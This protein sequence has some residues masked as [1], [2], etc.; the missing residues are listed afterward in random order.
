MELICE[1]LH[2]N[3]VGWGK[4]PR[5]SK[6]MTIIT[7]KIDGTNAQIF[8]PEDGQ[9]L[10]GSRNRWITPDDDNFG[11]ARWVMEHESEI[12]SLGKGRH[13]GEWYGQGIQRGYG[14]TEKRF[15][16]FNTLRPADSLPAC[17]GQVPVL[18]SGPTGGADPVACL[19]DLANKGSRAVPGWMKPEGLVVWHRTTDSRYK[20]LCEGDDA[21]KFQIV[22]R[23][24]D[25]SVAEMGAM[26]CIPESELR[27][28]VL[29]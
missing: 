13:F 4:I 6:E 22:P 17:I 29:V 9:L 7:E 25:A 8:M 23:P 3:F 26:M 28:L 11:F 19:D 10:I 12:R 16:L 2:H 20:K 27:G 14:L 15:A 1:P 5:L 18:Y 21:H 24:I